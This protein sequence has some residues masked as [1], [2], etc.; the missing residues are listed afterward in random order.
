MSILKQTRG[1]FKNF[2]GSETTKILKIRDLAR[3]IGK[4]EATLPSVQYG[5]LYLWF[6]HQVKTESLNKAK[7]SFEGNFQLR[8]NSLFKIQWLEK[9]LSSI[10]IINLEFPSA[11][12][13]SDTLRLWC[14]IEWMFYSWAL[15][16]RWVTQPYKCIRNEI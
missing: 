13:Y 6:L 2:E 3:L 5:C 16:H 9:N 14:H 8:Q 1:S 7:G 12:I 10:N 4:F 15:E 11:I